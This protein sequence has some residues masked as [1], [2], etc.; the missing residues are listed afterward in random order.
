MYLFSVKINQTLTT[1]LKLSISVIYNVTYRSFLTFL[2]QKP[3]TQY[4]SQVLALSC[5]SDVLD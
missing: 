5:D 4:E 2:F 3:L 1:K